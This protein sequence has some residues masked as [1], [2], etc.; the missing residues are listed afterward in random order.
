[1]GFLARHDDAF[2]ATLTADWGRA[3]QNGRQILPGENGMD[4]FYYACLI[5]R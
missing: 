1:V 2:E 5:K 4:G 3:M